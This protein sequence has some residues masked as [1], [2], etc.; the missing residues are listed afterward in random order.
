MQANRAGGHYACP[1][2]KKRLKTKPKIY[3]NSPISK[4]LPSSSSECGQLSCDFCPVK[5]LRAVK[6]CLMCTA[7]YCETHVI[8]HYTVP[9]L[10]RHRLVEPKEHLE[11]MI[12]QHHQRAL[13]MF[14]RTDQTSI[15]SMCA[16]LKHRHHDIMIEN[17]EQLNSPWPGVSTVLC[18]K[19]LRVNT[20]VESRE[21]RMENKLQREIIMQL[22]KVKV[23]QKNKEAIREKK[24]AEETQ[25][26]EEHMS[27]LEKGNAKLKTHN[28]KLRRKMSKLKKH[29]H[30]QK[31]ERPLVTVIQHQRRHALPA[32][33]TLDFYTA[34]RRLIL[35]DDKRNVKLSGCPR[36]SH[37]Q[38]H[39]LGGQP[40]VLGRKGFTSGRRFWQVGVNN[41]WTI[42]VTRASA[43]RTDSV[44]FYP[45]Q[46][47]WCLSCWMQFLALTSPIHHLPKDAVPRELGIC[48]DIDEKWVSFYNAESKTHI[49]TFADMD[50]SEGEEIYPV[51]CTL[52]EEKEIKIRRQPILHCPI[53]VS[54]QK[55]VQ[56]G[57]AG[58]EFV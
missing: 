8:Q 55:M 23:N 28:N 17:L 12:C 39:G 18:R 14:C 5:K 26:M 53:F 29:I 15:C 16:V 20:E 13:E 25:Q 27:T 54:D 40:F 41:R 7:L 46:G 6:F 1:I 51:F 3:T 24:H 38:Q 47:Y 52:D 21:L 43:Q 37:N 50:F 42:G 49:Y 2:C 31:G 11:Q 44:T 56:T 32:K 22:R 9:A 35:S 30:L 10:Q 19:A 4:Q 45:N 36:S 58:D 33:V 34:H 48:L 57:N